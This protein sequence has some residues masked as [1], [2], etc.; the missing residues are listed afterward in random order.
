MNKKITILWQDYETQHFTCSH[1]QTK[2]FGED[3]IHDHDDSELVIPLDCPKCERRVALL[4]IQ[5]PKED[6]EKVAAQAYKTAFA[7]SGP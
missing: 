2:S 6:I 3:L 7:F 1:C 4:N 5:A